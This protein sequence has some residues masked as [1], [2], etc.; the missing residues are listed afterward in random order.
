MKKVY[1]KE[2][3]L[4]RVK[5]VWQLPVRFFHWLNVLSILLLTSTGLIIGNPPALMIATEASQNYWFGI[6]RYI[7][8]VSA[9]V[10][11][12][13]I[14]FR[15]YWGFVGNKYANW[16]NFIPYSKKHW[17]DIW[18]VIKIDILQ[19]EDKPDPNLGHNA[20]ASFTYFILFITFILQILTGF[21]MYAAMSTSSIAHAF[22]WVH[23]IFDS[24]LTLRSIHHFLTWFFIVFSIIHVY[25][26]FYHDYIEQ[27]G[28]MSSM[29][30]G[31]KFIRKD[32][33]AREEE[34]TKID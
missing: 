9:Y 29:I 32:K 28:V 6:V 20:L 11:V 34:N 7:H 31:W 5:Y 4:M 22:D 24:D 17:K 3:P 12:F 13:N 18:N 16:K 14:I 25:L 19:I 23:S 27:N 10:F 8:F 26:V 1:K 30:S 2:D 15:T 33:V 21:G